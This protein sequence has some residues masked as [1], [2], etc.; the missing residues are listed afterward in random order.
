MR[1]NMLAK[2]AVI[3]LAAALQLACAGASQV[4]DSTAPQNT[5]QPSSTETA[6]DAVDFGPG[7]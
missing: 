3:A 5:Q 7:H 2:L 1:K 4:L 6:P